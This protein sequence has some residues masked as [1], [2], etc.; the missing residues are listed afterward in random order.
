MKQLKNTL[1]EIEE[2][3]NTKEELIEN[4]QFMP[5]LSNKERL[6][7]LKG[8]NQKIAKLEENAETMILE[9]SS[10]EGF[11]MLQEVNIRRL[12]KITQ[13]KLRTI[14]IAIQLA[15]KE[16]DPLYIKYAR[17]VMLRKTNKEL[18]LRKYG[19]KAYQMAM[20]EESAK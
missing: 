8:I 3:K 4:E 18:I 19:N 6:L 16:N 5:E 9:S 7:T 15:K 14:F 17:G 13:R 1:S 10:L 20:Q 11:E 2:L 12:D